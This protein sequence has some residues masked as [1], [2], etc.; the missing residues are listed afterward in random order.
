MGS[1]LCSLGLIIS[2]TDLHTRRRSVAD[3]LKYDFFKVITYK[4]LA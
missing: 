4:H 1:R 2:S 3:G